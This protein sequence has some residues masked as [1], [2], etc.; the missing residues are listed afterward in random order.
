MIIVTDCEAIVNKDYTIHKKNKKQNKK[1]Y[2][3]LIFL[4]HTLILEVQLLCIYK[5]VSD[6][7]HNS[8]THGTFSCFGHILGRSLQFYHPEFNKEAIMKVSW[9][10]SVFFW[11]G[12]GFKWASVVL[13]DLVSYRYDIKV[14]KPIQF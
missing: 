13:V 3:N 12:G 1:Y 14:T 6:S 11:G 4:R 9:N 7:F 8:L 10:I 5:D 2:W